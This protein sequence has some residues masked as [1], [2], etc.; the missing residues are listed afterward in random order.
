MPTINANSDHFL[1]LCRKATTVD[2]NDCGTK[3]HRSPSKTLAYAL[4]LVLFLAGPTW[5]QTATE[6]LPANE[7][8]PDNAIWQFGENESSH[9]GFYKLVYSTDGEYLAARNSDNI[10]TVYDT[11]TRQPIQTFAGHDQPIQC[12]DFS[13][14][15]KY[16]LTG[17]NGQRDDRKTEHTK[18]W[19]VQTGELKLDL[20]IQ[21]YAA[22]FSPEGDNVL[23]MDEKAVN[24]I[25]IADGKP[26]VKKVW[27]QANE[28]PLTMSRDGNRVAVYRSPIAGRVYNLS[29]YNL[30][31][32]STTVLQ[33]NIT[34][35]KYATFSNDNLHLAA[36]FNRDENAYLWDL[37]TR[38]QFVLSGHSERTTAIAFSS[39]S[40][41]LASTGLDD[42]AIIWDLFTRQKITALN[43]HQDNV[44][45]V[46]FAPL[47]AKLV[48]GSSGQKDNR[49]IVWNL[50][51][52]LF[53]SKELQPPQPADANAFTHLW[54]R[55]SA[56]PPQHALITTRKLALGGADLLGFLEEKI[57]VSTASIDEQEI[58]KLIGMLN[59]ELY[60][61]R[62]QASI[63]LKEHGPHAISLANQALN[64]AT[65]AEM[66]Y[67]I[68]R[69]LRQ[70][71]VRPPIDPQELC[72]LHRSIMALEMMA[73]GDAITTSKQAAS[74]IV[75]RAIFALQTLALGHENIDVA[76]DAQAALDRIAARR[77]RAP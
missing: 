64:K 35:P 66:R 71:V 23:I 8:L 72:R 29:I 24:T 56:R 25:R 38:T 47:D 55:M 60:S 17:A 32:K 14:D 20:N 11:K 4:L 37:R 51:S 50:N 18:I 53:S 39:D 10:V 76:N 22:F 62:E 2:R 34:L 67:R 49:G 65:T 48:T 54:I 61:E 19:N 16:I 68:M 70:P 26:L 63:A 9:N 44:N 41:F 7:Q 57:G 73:N 13:K 27:K 12:V 1:S 21:A 59:S 43:A 46:T 69:L 31:S 28:R 74:D 33:G 52:L 40:R 75:K 42:S 36:I 15:G 3:R 5:G 77:Q 45:S 30:S 6:S 58:T